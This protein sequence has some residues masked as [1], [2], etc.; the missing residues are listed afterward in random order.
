L[1]G[2]KDVFYPNCGSRSRNVNVVLLRNA[3][4]VTQKTLTHPTLLFLSG[5]D[6]K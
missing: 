5:F 3:W 2:W 6:A 4:R 1:A